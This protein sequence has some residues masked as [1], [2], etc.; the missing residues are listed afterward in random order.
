[1]LST[2]LLLITYH[3]FILKNFTITCSIF[4]KCAS[5]VNLLLPNPQLYH[6]VMNPTLHLFL[7]N[8]IGLSRNKLN[9]PTWFYL[10]CIWL[11]CFS[12]CLL[13]ILL[14]W[15]ASA[16]AVRAKGGNT[17][18]VFNIIFLALIGEFHAMQSHHICFPIL[19][20][21]SYPPCFA[22]S[23]I[24]HKYNLSFPNT[25]MSPVKITESFSIPSRQKPTAV[26]LQHLYH[27]F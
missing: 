9:Y 15:I 1:M 26:K 6:Y 24:V 3:L 8:F 18:F 11:P 23:Q 5:L 25:T 7:I 17:F 10:F 14:S 22:Q 4:L 21:S 13:L 12:W 16:L 2:S 19:P 27:N 20:G